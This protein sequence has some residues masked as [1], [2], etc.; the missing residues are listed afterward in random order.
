MKL[1]EGF[2]EA[3]TSVGEGGGTQRE[4]VRFRVPIR[5]DTPTAEI[6][7]VR[8]PRNAT[9]PAEVD[10][11][12]F[13]LAGMRGPLP[14]WVAELVLDR[15]KYGDRAFADFLDLFHH[16]LVSLHYRGRKKYRPALDQAQPDRSRAARTG[17]ALLG[18]GSPALRGRL[19]VRDRALL[20]YTGLMGPGPRSQVGLI[21]VL[22]E[23]FGVDVEVMPFQGRWL[24]LAEQDVTRLGPELVGQNQALG[25]GT[26]L[27]HKVWDQ[28][29]AIE[30]RVG[31]LGF[32][33]FSGFLPTGDLFEKLRGL[34][35]F[36]LGRE[37]DFTL[38]LIIA[39]MEVPELRLG[40][41]ARL[42]WTSWLGDVREA[43]DSQVT[44]INHS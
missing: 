23:Y 20:P 22:E 14:D 1:L 26:V 4:K 8:A 30:I 25:H 43:V 2:L 18:L 12:I 29:A 11:N 21:R 17:F 34:A 16:R 27:G 3:Q 33:K 37:I 38:R 36:Y 6:E 15:A 31:P 19:S 5:L 7:K 41:G 35:R 40:H 39:G 32:E 9:E 10:V 44:L 24:M 28:S 42:G 13:S